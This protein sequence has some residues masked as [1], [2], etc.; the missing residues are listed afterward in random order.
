MLATPTS[1]MKL[2]RRSGTAAVVGSEYASDG[3]C[4]GHPYAG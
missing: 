2:G 4:G 3:A 1:V